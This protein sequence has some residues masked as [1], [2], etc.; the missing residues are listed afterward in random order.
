MSHTLKEKNR[1][2]QSFPY[3]SMDNP[4]FEHSETSASA[5]TNSRS[6]KNDRN[7]STAVNKD[8]NA[9]PDD[10][11]GHL[12]SEMVTE[13]SKKVSEAPPG[14]TPDENK[15]R[16]VKEVFK[17][18]SEAPPGP[19]PDLVELKKELG[20]WDGV[21]IIIG[22]I[23]GSGIFVSPSNVLKYTGSV[24][25]SLTIWVVTGLMTMTGALCYAELGTMIPK[26][27]GAYAYILEA[28]GPIPAFLILSFHLTI[29][30]PSSRAINC[31]TF[32]TYLLQPIFP[33]CMAP[34]YIAVRLVAAAMLCLIVYI[35]CSGIKFGTRVQDTFA[36]LK[37]VSLIVII[38]AGFYH[39]AQGHVENLQNAMEGTVYSLS[40]IATAFYS[41]LFAYSG[42]NSLNSITEELK[43]P[44]RNLPRAI[45][46]SLVTVIIV[47]TLTNI[48]YFAVLTPE[49]ILASNAVA[50]TFGSRMLGV[51]AWIISLF[52]AC[53]TFGNANG[54]IITQSRLQ[55][56]GAREGHLPRFL[57]LIHVKNY[58]PIT[59]IICV[60]IIPFFMLLAPDLGSLL[61]YT[62]F[63]GNL[64]DLL[65]VLALLWLRYKDPDRHRP[66]KVWLGFPIIFLLLTVF[67]VTFPVVQRPIEIGVAAGIF[68]CGLIV[69][70]FTI[71]LKFKFVSNVMDKIT[72]FCQ[73]LLFC[74][75][76]EKVE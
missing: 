69:Y 31:L 42:W 11:T 58:T 47:Y 35:N 7:E 43:D 36:I 40:S 48:A 74:V 6:R 49:E 25:M 59:S 16:L 9:V 41:T 17:K 34:P 63:S 51:L 62:S 55:F 53:S 54:D 14:S 66:I 12:A 37:V 57:T 38:V 56:V 2:T 60:V 33:S 26:S 22:I 32:A 4:T 30:I 15:D 8:R 21:S 75:E 24:G 67:V 39:M 3:D 23:I 52:V 45:A 29:L 18:V 50:V 19:I 27:G 20:L 68:L 1:V 5:S 64:T 65:C 72:H 44:Y 10:N 71:H 70:Y 46:I 28:F 61:A 13:V 73:K 76:E